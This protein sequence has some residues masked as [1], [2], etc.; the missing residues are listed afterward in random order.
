MNALD[1][2]H[3]ARCID[4][5]DYI[6]NFSPPY[7]AFF[8]SMGLAGLFFTHT[9]FKVP[10]FRQPENEGAAFSIMESGI[11]KMKSLDQGDWLS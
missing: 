3:R 11:R 5:S 2:S 6:G 8:P 7:F 1:P 10:R 4:A 9:M